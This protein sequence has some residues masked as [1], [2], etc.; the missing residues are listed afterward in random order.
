MKG[1]HKPIP[2]AGKQ[3]NQENKNFS[4]RRNKQNDKA[5]TNS[6][7]RNRTA[8]P[9][10]ASCSR[11]GPWRAPG[12]INP[13]GKARGPL[14]GRCLHLLGAAGSAADA[15]GPASS[16]HGKHRECR[17][18]TRTSPGTASTGSS[19]AGLADIPSGF[20]VTVTL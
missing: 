16:R 12:G 1:S 3:E 15:P 20:G 7:R 11:A 8:I 4:K 19:T 10:R 13:G 6:N 2:Q 17:H 14:A 9:G 18:G 5:Q